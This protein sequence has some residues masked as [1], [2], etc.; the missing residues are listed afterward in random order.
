[1]ER[2]DRHSERIAKGI[3]TSCGDRLCDECISDRRGDIVLCFEC[4]VKA[5]AG[6]FEKWERKKDA[7]AEIRRAKIKKPERE[8]IGGFGWFLIITLSIIALESGIIATDYL[9]VRRGEISRISS[10]TI[11]KRY[12]LDVSSVNMHKISMAIEKYK[13]GHGGAP[14]KELSALVPDYLGS[15]PAD[16]VT[17]LD[18][19]YL[20]E[21]G[22]YSVTC[23][24]PEAHGM[25]YLINVNGKLHYK[26]LE[27]K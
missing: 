23:S 6:D 20:A 2:C 9:V 18:Y 19:E 22:S 1:M 11:T 12:N 24:A 4:A 8:G 25:L 3:C 17:G 13:D 16:P 14:P 27:E 21:D 15:I 10:N 7:E 26:K 5:T